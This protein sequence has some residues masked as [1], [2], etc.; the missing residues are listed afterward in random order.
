MTKYIWC[1]KSVSESQV[2]TELEAF[3][4]LGYEIFSVQWQEYTAFLIVA[5]KKR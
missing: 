2:E 1:K 4:D 3:E 5:R